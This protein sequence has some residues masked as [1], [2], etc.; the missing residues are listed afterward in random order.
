MLRSK[1]DSYQPPYPAF[2][3]DQS[4]DQPDFVMAMLGV[5]ANVESPP[6]AL[7]AELLAL[8][9]QQGTGSPAH[10][11]AVSHVDA[12]GYR[13]DVFL[14]YWK[15]MGQMAAFFTRVDVA[16]FL[17]Q[18]LDGET[19]LWAERLAAP[20]TS[21][22]ANN[23]RPDV[24]YGIARYSL[25]REEQYHAYMGSMRDRVPDYLAGKANGDDAK[26]ALQG[27]VESKGRVLA[28]T[29]LP[30]NLCF[31]RGAF[32]WQDAGEEEQAAFMNRMMPV[33][34]EGAEYL[35]D[36]PVESGCIS[37]RM[38]DT[39]PMDED[40]GLQSEILGWFIRL[41]AL[42]RWTRHHPRHLAI[43]KT[44]YGYMEEFSFKPKLHL[45]HEVV[46]IPHG[47]AQMLYNNCHPQ[48]GFLPFFPADEL[49]L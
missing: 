39:V 43:M 4:P 34:R 10:V 45:G 15:T 2:Q 38:A 24:Q 36:N 20:T 6:P 9:R 46:V 1:P 16:E 42:E 28:I 37:M 8:C 25:P 32:A 48:T 41:E 44:I 18:P 33:Y 23:A 35:R 30:H 5:Q 7:V 40:S 21:L 49:I 31:I 17:M 3:Q 26:L 27:D 13:N 11:E 14:P 22:D 19:G 12:H 47:Q 29:D